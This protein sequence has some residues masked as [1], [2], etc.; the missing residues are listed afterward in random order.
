MF[1][2]YSLFMDPFSQAKSAS[3]STQTHPGY[4]LETLTGM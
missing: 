3:I 4:S 1:K 2:G